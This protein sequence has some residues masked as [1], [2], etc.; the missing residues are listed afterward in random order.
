MTSAGFNGQMITDI[1]LTIDRRSGDVVAKSARNVAVTRDVEPAPVQS[2]LV[3]RYRTLAAKEASR[4]AG[5]ITAPISS[6]VDAAGESPLGCIIAD[7]MLAAASDPKAGGAVVAFVNEGGIR[8]DLTSGAGA[9][10]GALTYADLFR[11][12][13]FGNQLI[14]KT[15]AGSAL[16][17]LL[18]QQFDNPSTGRDAIL[19][20]SEGFGYR[21]NRSRPRGQRVD[22]TSV[23]LHGKPL[24]PRARYRVVMSDFLW[25]AATA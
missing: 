6:E 5:A 19:Q 11:V 12:Q 8:A 15:L 23:L 7:A 9:D 3:A 14:V 13:P 20:V 24:D 10:G 17:R 2:A 22:R 21:Y 18:E 4:P 25:G 1:D 16:L